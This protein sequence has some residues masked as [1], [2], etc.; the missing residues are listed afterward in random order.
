MTKSNSRARARRLAG[1]RLCVGLIVGLSAG[2]SGFIQSTTGDVMS[3]YSTEH[4][5]PWVLANGDTGVACETGVSLVGFL[6]SFERVT[7]PPYGAAVP[8]LLSAA[9]C[10]QKDAFEADLASRRAIRRADVPAAKDARIVEKRLNVVAA[11]RFLAAW[12]ATVAKFGEPGG[13][14]PEFES[15]YDELVYTLGLVSVVQALQ[16]DMAAESRAGVPLDAPAKAA[17][18]T[19][20]LNNARWWGVPQALR[21]VIW[22]SIPGTVP[23]G[24]DPW[25]ELAEAA[26]IG[27]KAGVR[28]A[29]AIQAQ[30]AVG[31]G[32]DDVLRQVIRTHAAALAATPSAEAY[33][34]VDRIGTLQV[35]NLSDRLWT[36]AEG[37]RTP[38]GGLGTFPTSP[39]DEDDGDL[40]EGL[41]DEV[42]PEPPPA[43]GAPAPPAGASP[44]A[45]EN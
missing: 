35:M 22:I 28:L 20:C 45:E 18:A 6:V 34:T 42:E 43:E 36:D 2:C 31:A 17:R 14:C 4:L 37:H 41:T 16:H 21:A 9:V 44:P 23:D 38:F 33:K 15:R 32:K 5:I 12:Q 7:D 3:D 40:L 8:T 30:A 25:G 11:Q 29:H 13:A 19:A 26:V 39:D 27:E 24:A 10:A 1:V